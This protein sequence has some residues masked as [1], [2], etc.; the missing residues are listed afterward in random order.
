MEI[1]KMFQELL[2]Q[3]PAE[4]RDEF[5]WQLNEV[6]FGFDQETQEARLIASAHAAC[7]LRLL[8]LLKFLVSMD[9]GL[10]QK[11]TPI[12]KFSLVHTALFCVDL[13]SLE[14]L[15]E[16]GLDLQAPDLDGMS[17]AHIA[18]LYGRADHLVFL[19]NKEVDLECRDKLG[20]TPAH[21]PSIHGDA[22]CLAVLTTRGVDLN[23]LDHMGRTPA[24]HAAEAEEAYQL[25][26]LRLLAAHNADLW[27]KDKESM[28]PLDIAMSLPRNPCSGEVVKFIKGT[29]NSDEVVKFIR[30]PKKQV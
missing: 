9:R 24:H 23:S 20:R 30:V 7:Q 3:L 29:K 13:S 25:E 22:S 18:A 28:T 16:M 11:T 10:L 21:I 12:S 4:I 17:P 6:L 14:Y 27:V 2:D 5:D 1:V 15:T 19:A 8:E 26:M